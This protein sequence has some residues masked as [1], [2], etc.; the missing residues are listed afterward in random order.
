MQTGFRPEG[1]AIDGLLA[2]MMG[3]KK[4]QEHDLETWGVYVDLVKAFGTVNRGRC[5]RC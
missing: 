1:G 5:G 4:R 3:L 2:V